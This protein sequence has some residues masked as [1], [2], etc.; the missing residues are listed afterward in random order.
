MGRK[1][2][3]LINLSSVNYLT[4][5]IGRLHYS[6]VIGQNRPSIG[7]MLTRGRDTVEKRI[8]VALS[9]IKN[10]R[11]KFPRF[12][13]ADFSTTTDA[14]PSKRA[15][16]DFLRSNF[17]KIGFEFDKFDALV[18]HYDT[19]VRQQMANL[20]A[21]SDKQAPAILKNLLH[22]V[23]NASNRISSLIQVDSVEVLGHA[24]V[25]TS[26]GP[27]IHLNSTHAGSFPND[28]NKATFIFGD[29]KDDIFLPGFSIGIGSVSF[30]F[31]WQNPSESTISVDV[32]ASLALMGLCEA[33]TAGATVAGDARLRVGAALNIHELWNDPP[34]SPIFQPTQS[35]PALDVHSE[36]FLFWGNDFDIQLV[37]NSFELRYFQFVMPPKGIAMF[38]VAC[39]LE[40]HLSGEATVE[41]DFET[42][43]R[44][45]LCPYVEI[46]GTPL[47]LPDRKV[48]ISHR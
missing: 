25:I 17:T 38:E 27:H 39:E 7:N 13:G 9:K 4:L 20:K 2:G 26:S 18:K 47:F 3:A 44:Q 6:N 5:S 8:E 22:S 37:A 28:P 14:L 29:S 34:T 48:T 11:S 16:S 46:N 10:G 23:E 33:A 41:A 12:R 1:L 45:V 40:C 19:E 30:F 24:D 31:S 32:A 35:L 42:F 15:I 21:E 36:T 43:G